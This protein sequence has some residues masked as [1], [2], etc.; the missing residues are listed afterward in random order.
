MMIAAM[1][2]RKGKRSAALNRCKTYMNDL[3]KTRTQNSDMA[4]TDTLKQSTVLK[5]GMYPWEIRELEMSV[6]TP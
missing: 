3:F 4:K 6:K 2:R 1:E 5:E